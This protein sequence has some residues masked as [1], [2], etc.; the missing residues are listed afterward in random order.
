MIMQVAEANN[1]FMAE[2]E[3][4]D[5]RESFV[6]SW[7]IWWWS[8]ARIYESKLLKAQS[9]QNNILLAEMSVV[10]VGSCTNSLHQVKK[11]S[12]CC[13]LL[14]AKCWHAASC[15]PFNQNILSRLCIV[16]YII[17]MCDVQVKSWQHAVNFQEMCSL[18]LN[19]WCIE[20]TPKK[21]S[22]AGSWDTRRI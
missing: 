4:D 6:W 22:L 11:V 5:G 18:I 17:P 7:S 9:L 8:S 20:A 2:A 1:S 10:Y 15:Q 12:C 13:C 14:T 3:E 16:Y 19:A 21:D